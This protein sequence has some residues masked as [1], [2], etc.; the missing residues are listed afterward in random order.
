MEIKEINVEALSEEEI[1]EL[2]GFSE[3]ARGNDIPYH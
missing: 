2:E 3:I 1:K